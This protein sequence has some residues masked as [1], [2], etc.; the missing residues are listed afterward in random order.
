[1][2]KITVFLFLIGIP[3]FIHAQNDLLRRYQDHLPHAEPDLS[4]RQVSTVGKIYKVTD[5]YTEG[6]MASI[7]FSE[8]IPVTLYFPEIGTTSEFYPNG[9]LKR[10]VRREGDIHHTTEYFSNGETYR[11]YRTNGEQVEMISVWGP[12]GN[13]LVEEGNGKAVEMHRY[14][15]ETLLETGV[16]V[17]G[18]RTGEWKGDN[19]RPYFTEVYKAGRLVSGESWDREGKKFTYK[20][21]MES[22]TFSGGDQ[23][24][25]SFIGRSIRMPLGYG[26]GETRVNTRFLVNTEGKI[27]SL[28]ILNEAPD[29]FVNE[30]SRVIMAT[31]GKW[32]AGKRHGQ[33][34]KMWFTLPINFVVK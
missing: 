7:K 12:D 1:M 29:E 14:E 32:V 10:S 8:N 9:K 21:K 26:A 30:A 25:Y 13:V 5:R 17:K 33:P 24:L 20:V 3:V 18:L 2:T 34:V 31:S 11:E 27:D 6:E 19:G 28:Q 23:K 22:V 4:L 16:Y 15:E